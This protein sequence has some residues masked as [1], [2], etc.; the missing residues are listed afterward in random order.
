MKENNKKRNTKI[1]SQRWLK[2]ADRDLKTAKLLFKEKHFTDTIC[3]HLHQAAEKYLKGFL[4]ARNIKPLC[5][6]NLL[7]L[8]NECAKIQ[9]DFTDWAEECEML[10]NYYIES[11]YSPDA[12]ID[13]PRDETRRAIEYVE[14]LI[15]FIRNKI[16]DN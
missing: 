3:F 2:V 5:I 8:L 9:K 7:K 10:N 16:N 4:V 1:L 15:K 13:Y 6:H 12:P 14:E 11:R